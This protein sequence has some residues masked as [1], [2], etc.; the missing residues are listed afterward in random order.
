MVVNIENY[1]NTSAASIGICLDMLNRNGQ[2][3]RGDL[4]L[5]TSFGAG[6]TWATTLIRW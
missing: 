6:L 4:V 5:M 1:G 2:L 3:R